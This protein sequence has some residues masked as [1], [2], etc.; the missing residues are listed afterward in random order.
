MNKTA[1][2]LENAIT[3]LQRLVEY[4]KT[5]TY[6]AHCKKTGKKPKTL[7]TSVNGLLNKL[8]M[9]EEISKARKSPTLGARRG[10]R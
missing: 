6:I 9:E 8:Y 1:K 2:E 4:C 10:G 3:G 5:N 7:I